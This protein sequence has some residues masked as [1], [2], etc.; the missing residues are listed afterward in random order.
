MRLPSNSPDFQAMLVS[1]IR[2]QCTYNIL[3]DYLEEAND[4][5]AN[6]V[7]DWDPD[8]EL[9]DLM[10]IFD[11]EECDCTRLDAEPN[12]CE[13]CKGLRFVANKVPLL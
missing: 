3:A 7:R 8:G 10:M 9:A 11:V 12:G 6:Q 4:P 2:G 5:R 1:V 13:I